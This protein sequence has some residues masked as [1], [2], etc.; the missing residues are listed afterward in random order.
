MLDQAYEQ[1]ESLKRNLIVSSTCLV[2]HMVVIRALNKEVEIL[3]E[4]R[5][6]YCMFP[7]GHIHIC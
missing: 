4:S 5:E 6:I 7:F 1:K 2:K 3:V